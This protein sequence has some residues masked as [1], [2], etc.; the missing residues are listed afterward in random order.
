M[1]DRYKSA[2]T[3]LFAAI[4]RATRRT[5]KLMLSLE[6]SKTVETLEDILMELKANQIIAEG[7]M[8]ED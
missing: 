7:I 4:T 5:E 3:T 6:Y 2:Y 8:I 1:E